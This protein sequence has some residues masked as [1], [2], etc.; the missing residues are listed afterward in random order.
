MYWNEASFSPH[1]YPPSRSPTALSSNSRKATQDRQRL[2]ER[3]LVFKSNTVLLI[4]GTDCRSRCLMAEEVVLVVGGLWIHRVSRYTAAEIATPRMADTRPKSQRHRQLGGRCP[5]SLCR[6]I[7][8]RTGPQCV[9]V[10]FA[11][12][13]RPLSIARSSGTGGR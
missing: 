4:T 8:S 5:I 13:S 2:D 6:H 1:K 9:P 3:I 12:S 10:G 11:D 7:L